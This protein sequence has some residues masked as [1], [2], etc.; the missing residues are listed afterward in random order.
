MVAGGGTA[1]WQGSDRARQAIAML[2]LRPPRTAAWLPF[3]SPF[4]GAALTRR[5]VEADSRPNCARR[6]A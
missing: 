4:A 5:F 6:R 2:W 3:P 1:G